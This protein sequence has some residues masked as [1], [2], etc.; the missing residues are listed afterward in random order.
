VSTVAEYFIY[1][2]FILGIALVAMGNNLFDFGQ[3]WVGLSMVLYITGLGR[4]TACCGRGS[5]G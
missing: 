2:V 1:A 5:I 4:P 3:T